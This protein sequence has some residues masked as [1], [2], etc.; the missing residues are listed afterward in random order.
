MTNTAKAAQLARWFKSNNVKIHLL[1]MAID[2]GVN[3]FELLYCFKAQM[4]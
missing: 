3:P 1:L 4:L 2:N